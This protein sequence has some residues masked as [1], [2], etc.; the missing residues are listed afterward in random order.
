MRNKEKDAAQMAA[1]RQ[2]FLDAA[3]E[4]FT[5]KGIEAVS[6]D[7][8]AQKSGFGIATLYRHFT[9]KAS[10]VVDLATQKW[11][12]YIR[13]YDSTVSRENKAHMTGAEYLRYYLDSFLDL[14][15][16]HR[17]MLRFNYDLNSFL[18]RQEQDR[19]Y[20]KPY[21]LVVDGLG[22]AFHEVYERGVR[23]GTLNT[24]ISETTMFSSS[25]H[26]MLAAVTRY[27]VGLVYILEQGSDPETELVMLE[28]LL[29]KEYTRQP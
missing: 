16:N 8:I 24:D 20:L 28:K 29:L 11:E 9:N 19:G 14:Y 13:G 5:E 25:F 26:I 15:R 27:A 18:R 7:S 2:A 3:F 21:L 10:L 4:L 6:L 12:D 17:E 22:E 1:K 23:D